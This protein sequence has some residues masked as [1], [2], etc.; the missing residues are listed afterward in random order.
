MPICPKCNKEKEKLTKDH[1][2][3]KWLLRRLHN[4]GIKRCKAPKVVNEMICSSCNVR[5]GGK[6]DYSNPEVRE[7]MRWFAY[8]ILDNINEHDK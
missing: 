3:P 2:I 8:E 5:K 1:V 4:Y 7:F 6:L